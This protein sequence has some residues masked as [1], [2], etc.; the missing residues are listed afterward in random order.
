MSTTTVTHPIAS[1]IRGAETVIGF[2]RKWRTVNATQKLFLERYLEPCSDDFFRIREIETVASSNHGEINKFLKKKG[3]TVRLEQLKRKEFGVA[4]VLDLLVEWLAPGTKVP[5]TL[6]GAEKKYPGVRLKKGVDF[7]RSV[8]HDAPFALIETQSGDTVGMTAY[9]G[10]TADFALVEKAEA[11]A[12]RKQSMNDFDALYFPMV[13]LNQEIDI[14]WLKGMSAVSASGEDV[15]ISQARQQTK[16]RMSES[17]ARTQS[18]AAVGIRMLPA[19]ASKPNLV[20]NKPFLVWVTRPGLY[21]PLF[22][23]HVTPED[24]KAPKG[25]EV[26]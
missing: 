19:H 2:G 11:I 9:D 3:F 18:A 6:A 12:G 14:S 21:K 26:P 7:Y 8:N 25:L 1:G 22:V 5:I 23:G 4:S 20:I 10:D 24:W 16:F 13:D 15:M 17:G